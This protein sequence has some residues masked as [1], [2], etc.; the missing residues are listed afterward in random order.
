MS[1]PPGEAV[2]GDAFYHDY[3]KVQVVNVFGYGLLLIA[4]L[5]I[6]VHLRRTRSTAYLGDMEAAKKVLLP[7][8]EPLLWILAAVAFGYS[9][10][11]LGAAVASYSGPLSSP[12]Y[13][14]ALYMP[15]QFNSYLVVAYLSQPSLSLPSMHRALAI[16]VVLAAGAPLIALVAV[17]LETDSHVRYILLTIYRS[18]MVLGFLYR[19][20][21]PGSRANRRA[22]RIFLSFV[23][24]YYASFFSQTYM[25]YKDFSTEGTF[26][27]FTTSFWYVLAPFAIWQLLKADTEHWRGVGRQAILQHPTT[28]VHE[29]V[30]AQGLHVLLEV[31]QRDVIDFAHLKIDD[32]IGVGATS[33]VYKGLLRS[34]T[35]VAVKVYT[36]NE[37]SEA[38]IAEFSQETALCA[39]LKHPNIVAFYGMCVAPPAICLVSELCECSLDALLTQPRP[40][41]TDPLLAQVTLML[42]AARAVA[43][44][45]SFSPPFLHR[46]LKPANFLLD[47]N[48]VLKLTDFGES[49]SLS[50]R[51]MTIKG[52]I[53]Y[54]APE[55]IEGKQG[56][57]TYTH[58]ADVYSLA[59]TLW[60]ILHPGREKYPVGRQNPL[61]IFEMVLDGQRPPLDHELHPLLRDVLESAWCSQPEYR[62]SAVAIVQALEQVQEELCG[63]VAQ[64]L[65]R[66]IKCLGPRLAATGAEL[67]HCLIQNEYAF[68]VAEA[69]RLGNALMDAG[70]L[71]HETHERAFEDSA[72]TT[73]FFHEQAIELSQPCVLLSKDKSNDGGDSNY[74][75]DLL[76]AGCR[77]RQHAQGHVPQT[78][79]KWYQRPRK[80]VR[81][82]VNALTV[83]LLNDLAEDDALHKVSDTT[84]LS[85]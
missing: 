43:Y 70:L 58:V 11:Y 80:D 65:L 35:R 85:G 74:N 51:A 50:T 54:M 17:A 39:A 3:R 14:E 69:T 59:I 15:R 83:H 38:T 76:E 66:V 19:F 24:V 1:A 57:A 41:Y 77:C 32:K 61:K 49:R 52:T 53:E 13:A 37:I 68:T 47:T 81:T 5:S 84:S 62:P 72:T 82:K 79:T 55:V 20:V 10:F 30:S 9:S 64:N 42:D 2:L 34:S 40:A 78:K 8:F 75:A 18:F 71:H 16:A 56:V 67:T 28:K 44:L 6:I 45:H 7:A 73:Y 26:F 48:H 46:D 60:D 22:W 23:L 25:F 29:V 63:I 27:L 21:Y 4:S 36:P 31:H 33:D 12:V